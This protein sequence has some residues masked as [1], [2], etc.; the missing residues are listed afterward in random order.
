MGLN[1]HFLVHHPNEGKAGVLSLEG[2]VEICAPSSASPGLHGQ[3]NILV[4]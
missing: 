4:T 1:L 2:R 3:V